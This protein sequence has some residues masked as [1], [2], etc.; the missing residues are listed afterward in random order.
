MQ[1]NNQRISL[2]KI[3][4]TSITIFILLAITSL[5]AI[6]QTDPG[7]DPDVPIDGGI[8]FLIAAG[9]GYGIKKVKEQRELKNK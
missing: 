7:T 9:V 1:K 4:Y 5:P 3:L 8:G 6:A 2:E